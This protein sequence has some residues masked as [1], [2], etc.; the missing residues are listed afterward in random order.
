[1]DYLAFAQPFMCWNDNVCKGK[2]VL[3]SKDARDVYRVTWADARHGFLA[4]VGLVS[5][6]NVFN[7]SQTINMEHNQI[8]KI[9]YGI[10]SQAQ[11]LTKLNMKD[12][13]LT[14]LPLGDDCDNGGGGDNSNNN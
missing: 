12:N 6:N 5:Q 2:I 7:F 10:F 8:N 9:P 13:Q 1:M 4:D 14:A 3:M 11:N